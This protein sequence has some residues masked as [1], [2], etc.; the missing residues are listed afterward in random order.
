M[1][2]RALPQ[3]ISQE[4]VSYKGHQVV[5]TYD[6]SGETARH[7]WVETN[8]SVKLHFIQSDLNVNR[9]MIFD[10]RGRR[11]GELLIGWDGVKPEH[12]LQWLTKKD[13]EE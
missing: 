4:I 10:G 5:I 7:I 11:T 2:H 13:L 8:G 1:A 12:I 3:G 6:A 9:L